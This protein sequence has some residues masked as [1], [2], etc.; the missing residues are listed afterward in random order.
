MQKLI[1]QMCSTKIT[2]Q[3][4][5]HQMPWWSTASS[6]RGW[7]PTWK[8]LAGYVEQFDTLLPE[9]TV[10]EMLLYTAELKCPVS[11]SSPLLLASGLY[12][13]RP[14]P[15]MTYHRS[16]IDSRLKTDDKRNISFCISQSLYARADSNKHQS[17]V[18]NSQPSWIRKTPWFWGPTTLT[19]HGLISD[20][21]SLILEYCLVRIAG[22]VSIKKGQGGAAAEYASPARLQEHMHR[23]QP[24]KRHLWGPG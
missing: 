23:W 9:L 3:G 8:C 4:T 13:D 12:K 5:Y 19:L 1:K 21:M 16:A 22:S 2:N 14:T 6:I 17:A 7:M 15:L 20:P 24:G 10:A 11:V 18:R